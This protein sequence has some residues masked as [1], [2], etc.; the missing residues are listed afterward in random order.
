LVDFFEHDDATRITVDDLDRW[1]EKLL[2]EISKRGTL[3]SPTTVKDKYFAALRATLNWAVE[4][5]KLTEN[6]AKSI[7]IR[8]PKKVKLRERDFTALEAKSILYQLA[9]RLTRAGD[10]QT[11]K[12]LNL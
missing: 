10:S 12:S 3:R 11:D 9:M 6:A 8:V 4:T 1:R 2:G 5:R 7:V